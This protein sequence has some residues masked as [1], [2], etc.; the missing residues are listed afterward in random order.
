MYFIMTCI[1]IHDIVCHT[2]NKN[3]ATCAQPF[4][5]IPDTP[6]KPTEAKPSFR[7]VNLLP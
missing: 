4:K 6:S 5:E 3:L 1:E 7:K 2:E